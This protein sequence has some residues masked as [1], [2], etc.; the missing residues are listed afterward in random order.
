MR[1]WFASAV[2]GVLLAGCNTP[3][4]PSRNP[5]DIS[6]TPG[7]APS[8]RDLGNEPL[9]VH[10][11]DV[12]QGDAAWIEA[13]GDV[14]VLIDGG[15]SDAGPRVLEVLRSRGVE[16]LD[17]VVGT[18][19]HEDHIGGLID[20]LRAMPVERALDPGY[21]HGT[22]TQRTYLQLLKSK[23][24]KTVR[25]RAG[26]V[27]DLGPGT[28]LE[29]LAPQEPLLRNTES[30]ANNNSIVARL[31]HGDTRVLFTGDMEN[32]QRERLLD[33]TPSNALQAGILKVAHH[34]S[35]NGTDPRFLRTV[36]PR[37]AV[38]SL[39]DGNEYG[40]PHLETLDELRAAGIPVYRTDQLG[41]V[42]FESEGRTLRPLTAASVTH[43]AAPA[44][45]E[46]TP[47]AI[48]PVVGNTSSRVYHAPDCGS[49]P[50]PENRE[51]LATAA[52]AER[53][54][55]RPHRKCI[56]PAGR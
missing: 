24:V 41:D 43:K 18:H 49:L 8:Q 55:Y 22:A 52:E 17:W 14:D 1:F 11:L 36:A 13:P 45:P 29:V 15:P 46:T 53:A 48:G 9:R 12:G 31:V 56:N 35:H 47:Q 26:Q 38:V 3:V 39:A 30:D 51:R 37:F 10:F 34:G 23:G 16:Q 21:N 50:S 54:G 42:T 33:S 6:S 32:E 27:Y 19:P 2:M 40:H 28:Q 5:G 44:T 25:A 7:T 20:V 4:S